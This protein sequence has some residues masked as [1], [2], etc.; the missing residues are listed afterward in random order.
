MPRRTPSQR[1][2]SLGH[3][4]AAARFER[5]GSWIVRNLEEDVGIDMEAELSDP[6]PTADFLKCQ[7]KSLEGAAAKRP[8]RLKNKFLKYACE[9]RIPVVLVL[10][11]SVTGQSWFCW[12][13]GCI[14]VNRDCRGLARPA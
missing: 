10:V 14:E 1:I 6:D 12:L 11:E 9:C 8:V 2:G 7:I 4:V 13:Q 3:R 5:L